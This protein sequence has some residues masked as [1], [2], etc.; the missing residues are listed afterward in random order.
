LSFCG[1]I[2][3][4][5]VL[6]FL[7]KFYYKSLREIVHTLFPKPFLQQGGGGGGGTTTFAQQQQHSHLY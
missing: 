2:S 7:I 1:K 6:S 5:G 3:Y 4:F